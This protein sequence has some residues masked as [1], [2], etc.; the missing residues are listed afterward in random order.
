MGVV[1]VA[2]VAVIAAPMLGPMGQLHHH[3]MDRAFAHNRRVTG[4]DFVDEQG[5]SGAPDLT[6]SHAQL[7]LARFLTLP[8]FEADMPDDGPDAPA[9]AN[10]GFGRSVSGLGA[11]ARS[12]AAPAPPPGKPPQDPPPPPPP[13]PPGRAT[14][15]TPAQWVVPAVTPPPVTPDPPVP[16]VSPIPPVIVVTPVVVT[17]PPIS[18][19]PPDLPQPVLPVTRLAAAPPAPIPEPAT[20]TTMVLGLSAAAAALRRRRRREQAPALWPPRLV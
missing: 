3:K 2:C 14:S 18:P 19:P 10:M 11:I 15:P 20:W 5:P 13:E 6:F 17:T 9:A 4:M 8:R 1:A 16:P 12:P 7:Q